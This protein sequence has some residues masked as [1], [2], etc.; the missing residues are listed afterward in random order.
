MIE[1][2]NFPI[3]P[4]GTKAK[5]LL[6]GVFGPY[7]QDDE[8]GSRT[9]NPMELYHNQVTRVQGG[10]SLRMFHRSFGLVIIQLN[11]DSPCT[12]LEFPSLERFTN[13]IRIKQYDIIGIS[14]ILPNIGKVKKMCELI[15]QY[16]PGATI[17]VGGH[18]TNKTDLNQ[19]ID[20]DHIVRGEGIRWFRK[21]LGQDENAPI[22][23]PAASAGFGMRVMGVNPPTKQKDDSAVLIPSVGCPVGCNFCSTSAMFGGKGKF[24]NFYETGEQL[25]T[26]MSDIEKKLGVRSFFV[27]DENFL[28]HR[29]RA[30]ELLELI[31]KNDKS[32][33]FYVFSSA[34]VLKS[35][36]IEQLVELGVSWVWIGLEGEESKYQKLNG[37]DTKELVKEFQDNGIKV[38]GSTII[39]MENHTPE[40]IDSVIDYAVSHNTDFHQFMLYTP[41]PGT[42]LYREHLIKGDMIPES[43]FPLADSHGQYK[44]NFKHPNIHNEQENDFLIKAFQKDFEINGPGLLRVF[45]TTFKGW[46]KYRNH[47]ERRIRER[48]IWEAKNLR[49]TYAGA[50][51]AMR[52]VYGNNKELYEQMDSLLKEFYRGFGWKTRLMAPLFGSIFYFTYLLEERRL[53]NGFK[54]EPECIYTKNQKAIEVESNARN[55]KKIEITNFVSPEVLEPRF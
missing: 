55:Y 49:N 48:Y 35:Y 43:E 32:W 26:L 7:A 14:S 38:L 9:I 19:V 42:E 53:L 2:N 21:F 29:K 31:N 34:R 8:Y 39:G 10:F 44:F 13:E 28:L 1:K 12:L 36:T 22:K 45:R 54:Y 50:L 24:Q 18:V 5:I 33:S 41:L 6:T 16:Q 51:W 46:E 52:K 3:H 17:V 37:V 15:R 47:P 30:L 20:A 11:L 25:F 4:M 23:H 40:N 27:L